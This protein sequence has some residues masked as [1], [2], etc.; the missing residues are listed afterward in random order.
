MSEPELSIPP[1]SVLVVDDNLQGLELLVA[2]VE[3]L[4]D[5]TI[6]TAMDGQEALEM[7]TVE[8]PDL[9]LLDVMMPKMSGFDVCQ[10]LKGDPSTRDIQIMMVTA[11]GEVADLERAADCG[12]DDFLTKPIDR[13]TFLTR[14]KSLLRLRHLKKKK[15]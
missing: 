2:Y 11:L 8:Q 7:V 13:T 9:I 3:D 10:R 14:A 4:P 6:R 1:S 12:T 5:V 15:D